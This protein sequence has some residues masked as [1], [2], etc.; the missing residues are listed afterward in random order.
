MIHELSEGT[1]YVWQIPLLPHR[2]M[3][4]Y[5][6]AL[7]PE[8]L[9]R[10]DQF[11]F[12][13]H[14]ERWTVCRATARNIL[15]MCLPNQVE[16]IVIEYGDNGKPYLKEYRDLHFNISHSK[17]S[18]LLAITKTG[19]IGV[20]IERT[21]RNID[22]LRLSKR[23][24]APSEQEVLAAVAEYD[25]KDAFFKIWSRK[26]AYIKCS[27]QGLRIPLSSFAVNISNEQPQ[28][29]QHNKDISTDQWQLHHL[30][31][32]GDFRAACITS[33]PDTLV[34]FQQ[35]TSPIF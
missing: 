14:R 3:S 33:V 2:P 12:D 24:F 26:E 11:R 21:D 23:F 35:Y 20:D 7:I 1:V 9:S 32:V 25:R 19:P 10:A 16:P 17:D 34:K 30:D 4:H 5:R 18:A 13:V 15:K 6:A 27:G 8:E 28:I 29:L 22:L 31:V